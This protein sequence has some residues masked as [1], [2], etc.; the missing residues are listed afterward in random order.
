MPSEQ[1]ENFRMMNDHNR[2]SKAQ[3]RDSRT[4]QIIALSKYGYD[5]K[6]LTPYQFR[7]NGI[8]DIYPTRNK[9][10]FLPMNKRGEIDKPYRQFLKQFISQKQ[11]TSQAVE[12]LK[13]NFGKFTGLLCKD[14]I[15]KFM[16]FVW[17]VMITIFYF[18]SEHELKM[19]QRGD[20]N[21][22]GKVEITDL[23]IMADHWEGGK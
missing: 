6:E 2:F 22:D 8:L 1:V 17:V 11:T 4:E 18:V 23:S 16:F 13:E 5:V 19:A 10:H 15:L 9:Y 21:L 7:I 3:A 20:L 12:E 14:K